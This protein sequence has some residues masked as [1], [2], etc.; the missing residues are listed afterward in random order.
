MTWADVGMAGP[1]GVVL[2]II[3]VCTIAIYSA[4]MWAG[5]QMERA[6]EKDRLKAKEANKKKR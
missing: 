2:A 1:P 6:M 3:S 4:G 5:M